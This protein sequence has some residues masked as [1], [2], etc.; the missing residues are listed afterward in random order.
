MGL[1]VALLV[2]AA[3]L[4][5]T[6]GWA[7][8]GDVWVHDDGAIHLERSRAFTRLLRGEADLHRLRSLWGYGPAAYLLTAVFLVLAPEGVDDVLA[9]TAASATMGLAGLAGVWMLGR[10]VAGRWSGA[11][12]A[13]VLA[14]LPGWRLH[15]VNLDIDAAVGAWIAL[16][17]GLLL[18]ADGGRHRWRM[19]GAGMAAGLALT[20]RWMAAA[21]LV[22][23]FGV[24]AWQALAERLGRRQRAL[25][26]GLGLSILLGLGEA[27]RRVDF[28]IGAGLN[29]G[30]GI[31]LLGAAAVAAWR[32]SRTGNLLGSLL[33]AA[34]MVV[35]LFLKGR[36]G[37]LEALETVMAMGSSPG[38]YG[39]PPE[40]E[41]LSHHLLLALKATRTWHLGP[42][43]SA[44]AVVGLPLLLAR[45]R[46]RGPTLVLAATVL[47]HWLLVALLKPAWDHRHL[48]PALPLLVPLATC[49]MGLLPRLPAVGL[50]LAAA[51]LALWQCLAW[52]LPAAP[53]RS[54][55]TGWQRNITMA[56][57][58]DHGVLHLGWDEP[59]QRPWLTFAPFRAGGPKALARAYV[60]AL[61]TGTT[62]SAWIVHPALREDPRFS[63]H[64][65]LVLFESE[66]RR[67][68]A[69]LFTED[70]L[71]RPRGRLEDYDAWIV[72][73]PRGRKLADRVAGRLPK[74][75][76]RREVPYGGLAVTLLWRPGGPLPGDCT[77]RMHGPL[78]LL[79]E[80]FERRGADLPPQLAQP[81][82]GPAGADAAAP[83][84]P[85]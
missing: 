42:A 78:L 47:L 53:G 34:S 40:A 77:R 83:P 36:R 25:A 4:V 31:A 84:G 17:T 58:P 49:W 45:R 48:L 75:L 23:P 3:W 7:A 64:R 46:S 6:V 82:K 60:E 81:G 50:H 56:L 72:A 29:A 65:D 28:T 67:Q 35:P 8:A 85:R 70:L 16:S 61:G 76:E 5:G 43:W 19:L 20:T 26:I 18:T 66:A 12:A 30:V 63:V 11:V 2:V 27:Y 38:G 79:G 57:E 68:G 55:P 74:P 69:D 13:L 41:H 71:D 33:L 52:L 22:V 37:I 39:L 15:T 24:V 80:G 73:E 14:S 21:I 1:L 51:A 10:Q 54:D 62:C 44:A 59:S 32:G 9:A